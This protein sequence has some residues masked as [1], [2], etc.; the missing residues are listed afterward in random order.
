[1]AFGMFSSQGDREQQ[2]SP[3]PFD[4]G[5]SLRSSLASLGAV[6][7]PAAVADSP[8]PF[9]LAPWF[10]PGRAGLKGT[11]GSGN[12]GDASTATQ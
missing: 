9:S 12:P 11:A 8:A 6:L 5:V 3:E 2:E 7:A 4:S 10:F 1:M